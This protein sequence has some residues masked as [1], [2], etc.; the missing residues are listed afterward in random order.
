MPDVIVICSRSCPCKNL[1]WTN[2]VDGTLM[3]NA[4]L[5]IVKA[6]LRRVTVLFVLL[7][8]MKYSTQEERAASLQTLQTTMEIVQTILTH[9]G[10]SIRQLI[11]DDKGTVLIAVFGLPTMSNEGETLRTN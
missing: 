1:L 4:T 9:F 2:T 11:V 10:G 6:E 5:I 8:D 7:P 3:M